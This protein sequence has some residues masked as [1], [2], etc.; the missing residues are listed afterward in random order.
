MSAYEELVEW[1]ADVLREM[2][3]C[4]YDMAARMALAEVRRR[5]KTVTPEMTKSAFD[6][7]VPAHDAYAAWQS[8]LRAS[9]LTPP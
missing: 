8:M 2:P 6:Q 5:L 1:V 9:P 3:E 7:M 4:S